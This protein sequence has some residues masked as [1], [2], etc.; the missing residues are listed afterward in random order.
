VPGAQRV[1]PSEEVP[2]L[3]ARVAELEAD[4]EVMAAQLAARDAQIEAVQAR[5]AVLAGSA[6]EL[7]PQLWVS[8][9]LTWRASGCVL[10]VSSGPT[11]GSSQ[12]HGM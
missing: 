3:R 5:L 12:R 11:S 10:W 1:P 6:G 4:S 8:S 9:G 2:W 7:W